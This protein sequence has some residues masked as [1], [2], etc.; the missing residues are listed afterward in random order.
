[1]I[2]CLLKQNRLLKF[3]YFPQSTVRVDGDGILMLIFTACNICIVSR[4]L[5]YSYFSIFPKY[6]WPFLY[7]KPAILLP[8][9][10]TNQCL[11]ATHADLIASTWSTLVI[12]WHPE[13]LQKISE[14]HEQQL[15]NQWYMGASISLKNMRNGQAKILS[16]R[17][18]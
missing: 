5:L 2:V 18:S 12:M 4:I 14:E 1:M 11:R 9:N 6:F 13:W 16:L 3:L 15:T 10:K 7:L 17:A 8:N